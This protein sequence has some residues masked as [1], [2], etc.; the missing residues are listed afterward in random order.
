M[1]AINHAATALLLKRRYPQVPFVLALISVQFVEIVWVI[2]NYVGVEVT[3]TE[4][5]V[6]Y[7]GDIHL[8]HMPF[9]HSVATTVLIALAVWGIALT[10]GQRV[11][12]VAL[13]AGIASHLILDIATHN[14]DIAIAP[15]MNGPELGTYLYGAMP[16]LAFVIELAYGI[17]CW[18]AFNGSRALL[19]VIA[20]FNLG[21]ASLF[22]A[23]IPGPEALFANRPTLLVTVIFVQ[24]VVT[25]VAVGLAA[26]PS[27]RSVASG[28][29]TVSRS[30]AREET[31]SPAP[32]VH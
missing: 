17:F 26:R 21:N 18:W 6:R 12:G 11:L 19:A 15:F 29:G 8:A 23:A 24:I 7:V 22:F 20:L 30:A 3:T 1:F 5:V 13:A 10:L 28:P 31:S 2:L 16:A 25:L 32:T 4:P 9:S 27:L 14:G